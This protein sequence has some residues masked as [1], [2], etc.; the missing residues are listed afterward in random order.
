L[1]SQHTA[2]LSRRGEPSP[3][4]SPL[5]C[6]ASPLLPNNRSPRCGRSGCGSTRPWC[7][8]STSR[9]PL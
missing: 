4:F 1:T 7:R 2:C 8:S 3:C 5:P 9:A 6:L